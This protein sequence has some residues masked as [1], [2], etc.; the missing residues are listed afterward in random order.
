MLRLWGH[1]ESD[2]TEQL[3]WNW[4]VIP[5]QVFPILIK[6]R[7]CIPVLHSNIFACFLRGERR[8]YRLY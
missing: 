7:V 3:S 4:K 1:K 2:M 8:N 6:N 5:P